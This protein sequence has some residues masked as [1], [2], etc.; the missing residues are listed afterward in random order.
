MLPA[1]QRTDNESLVQSMNKVMA[2][3]SQYQYEVYRN[4]EVGAAQPC[5]GPGLRMFGWRAAATC[6]TVLPTL[7]HCIRS[8]PN[9]M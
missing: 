9:V 6:N 8:V 2:G 4:P 7:H 3:M 1:E 5:L